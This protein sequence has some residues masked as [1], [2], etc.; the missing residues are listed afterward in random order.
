MNRWIV[1][2]SIVAV[3]GI[4]GAL[5]FWDHDDDWGPDRGVD[6]ITRTVAADGTETIVI[7]EDGRH[8]FPFGLFILPLVIFFTIFALRASAFR[9]H[10]LGYGPWM[11]GGPGVDDLPGWFDEWHR[12]AH[13]GP[14]SPP[15]TGAPDP[16]PTS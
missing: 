16:G 1:A 10:S 2:A 11:H 9:G 14:N 13:A 3:V 4:G 6:V 12:R 7:R 15:A 5:A 8:F